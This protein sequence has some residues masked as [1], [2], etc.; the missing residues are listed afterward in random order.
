MSTSITRLQKQDEENEIAARHAADLAASLVERAHALES[1]LNDELAH[2]EG[3][4]N[5]SG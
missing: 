4:N 2:R 5:G 1:Q 3:R